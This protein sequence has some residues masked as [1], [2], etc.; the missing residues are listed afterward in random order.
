MNLSNGGTPKFQVPLAAM[1]IL[2]LILTGCD[3]KPTKPNTEQTS[4]DAGRVVDQAPST[5]AGKAM[6][7]PKSA[8]KENIAKSPGAADD[9]E[10]NIKVQT[11]LSANPTLKHLPIIVQTDA[12]VV[13]LSGTADT[14]DKRNQAEQV[15]MNV[16]GV[17]SV[18]NKLA[19]STM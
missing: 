18:E 11:A 10:L 17:K 6:D 4:G 8:E 2:A 3:P 15:A 14:P 13:T 19:V 7:Q 16:S 12:G 1:G 9:V 5:A